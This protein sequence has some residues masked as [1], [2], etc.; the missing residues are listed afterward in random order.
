MNHL[1][2]LQWALAIKTDCILCQLFCISF[3]WINLSLLLDKL[4]RTYH[5]VYL[6]L[7]KHHPSG[8]IGRKEF[9]SS[10]SLQSIVTEARAGAQD[11]NPEADTE[12]KT[13]EEFC[14]SACSPWFIYSRTTCPAQLWYYPLGWEGLWAFWALPPIT[15]KENTSTDLHTE[16]SDGGNYAVELNLIP[17]D[18]SLWHIEKKPN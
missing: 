14:S 13:I 10:H 18:S 17:D 2:L 8:N 12:A 9:V 4:S 3:V 1:T 7:D 15:D 11:R 16:Q 6:L 5:D